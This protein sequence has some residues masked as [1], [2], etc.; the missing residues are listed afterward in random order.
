MSRPS[1]SLSLLSRLAAT[2]PASWD[3]AIA[4]S[5]AR[6]SAL[7]QPHRHAGARANAQALFPDADAAQLARRAE[8]A[9]ARFLLEYL[10]EVG[11]GSP[12]DATRNPLTL[13]PGV[14][15]ALASGRGLVMC[16]AHIGNWEMG[17]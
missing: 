12:D 7:V 9:Y 8:R 6:A 3:D 13:G 11:R 1:V 14:E 5:L 17:A 2:L 15:E 4:A 10:R 16:T